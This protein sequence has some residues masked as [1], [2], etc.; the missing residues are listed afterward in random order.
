M[1]VKWKDIHTRF[2]ETHEDD[3]ISISL[4]IQIRKVGRYSA[5]H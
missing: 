3:K 5:K 1:G 4:I 2:M